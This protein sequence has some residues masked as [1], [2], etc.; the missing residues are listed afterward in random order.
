[1]RELIDEGVNAF[2]EV[3]PGR[4][5]TGLMR[6]IERSVASLN[7]EDEKSLAATLERIVGAKARGVKKTGEARKRARNHVL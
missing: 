4:V 6:Q 5:L 2:V 7:V 1:M 3:G